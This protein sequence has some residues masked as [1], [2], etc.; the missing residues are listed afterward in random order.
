MKL[1]GMIK[2]A[3]LLATVALGVAFPSKSSAQV[4][5]IGDQTCTQNYAWYDYYTNGEL[6]DSQ[7]EPDGISCFGSGSGGYN[8]ENFE[9]GG[10]GGGGSSSSAGVW[11]TVNGG[12]YTAEVNVVKNQVRTNDISCSDETESR[13]V[14]AG[15]ILVKNTFLQSTAVVTVFFSD[16]RQTFQRLGPFG[17]AY[18]MVPTSN[19][20]Q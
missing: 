11:V 16:G 10:G 2:G 4:F 9:G 12:G 6:T 18:Q 13:Q 8:G 3:V 7:Y 1:P 19:C 14:V 5:D 15:R 17:S 20:G